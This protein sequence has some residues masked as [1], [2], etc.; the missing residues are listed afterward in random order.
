[1]RSTVFGFNAGANKTDNFFDNLPQTYFQRAPNALQITRAHDTITLRH[2]QN[3]KSDFKKC[4]ACGVGYICLLGGNAGLLPS[5][6]VQPTPPYIS[7]AQTAPT[8]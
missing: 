5:R 7:P 3:A 4:Q 2:P 6:I 8:N 1:M